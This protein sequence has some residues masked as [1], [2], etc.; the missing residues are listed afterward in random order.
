MIISKEVAERA[1]ELTNQ[2][3]GWTD[4]ELKIMIKFQGLVLAFLDG[5]GQGWWLATT[6]LSAELNQFKSFMDCR[7]MGD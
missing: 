1:G 5:K 3:D 6:K 4:E 2:T 7:K